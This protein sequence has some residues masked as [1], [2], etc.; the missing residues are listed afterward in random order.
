MAPKRNSPHPWPFMAKLP[1]APTRPPEG[2]EPGTPAADKF[3]QDADRFLAGVG[4][5]VQSLN[6]RKETPK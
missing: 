6:P 5:L 1:P 4:G 2:L 3:A